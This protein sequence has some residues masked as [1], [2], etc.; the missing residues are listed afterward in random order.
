MQAP[1]VP[2]IDLYLAHEG[3]PIWRFGEAEL[4][5]I[6]IPDPFWA[7]AWAGGQ[8][9]ARY[10]LDHP[11]C[12]AGK[13]VFDFATGGGIIAIAALKAGA[14]AARVSDIDPLACQ[15][16]QMNAEINGLALQT[17]DQDVIG[18]D[19]GEEVILVGDA[20]YEEP[21]ASRVHDWLEVLANAGKM[22]LVGD[23]K[24]S[25]LQTDRLVSMMTYEVKTDRELE[26]REIRRTSVWQV[27]GVRA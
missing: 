9:L 3:C 26:D 4:E 8:A 13:T 14:K 17:T 20:C 15:V 2:E 10:I 27:R 6:G 21:L 18:A 16:A 12:V 5:E 23:P 19:L 1:L 22:V 24:R 25:Y 7:F 11:E